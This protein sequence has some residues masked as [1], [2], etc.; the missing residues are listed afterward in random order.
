M[1]IVFMGTP[2]FAAKPLQALIEAGH[3]IV[4]VYT[5]PPRPAGRG[6]KLQ[7]SAVHELAEAHDIPVFTPKNFKAQETRDELKALNADIGI[8]AAYGLILPQ[9]VLDIP[10]KGCLNIHGSL[11]PRWRGAA[12]IH[13]AILAGDTETGITIMRM[14]AGLDTGPMLLKQTTPI[15]ST[16]TYHTVHDRMAD[17]GAQLIVETV[18]KIDTLE[19]IVQPE[20]GVS[21][22][23]KITKEEGMLQ[24][25]EDAATIDRMIR[26]LSPWPGVWLNTG[27]RLKLVDGHSVE[28]TSDKPF[29]T[30]LNKQGDMAVQGGIYRVTFLQTPNGKTVS[31]ADAING[32]VLTCA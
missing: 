29:G 32:H 17:I 3:D 19:D 27:V 24:G 14:D 13:R 2:V 21:Y 12:P 25:T 31:V 1:R 8:V 16:D 9:A 23:H 6:H 4:G 10:K 11:L 18:H 26:A 5:Q 30:I 7:K 22:A 28:G 20:E 15:S